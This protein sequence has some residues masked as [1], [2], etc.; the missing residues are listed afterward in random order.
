[1]TRWGKSH[2]WAWRLLACWVALSGLAASAQEPGR[3]LH[4][5]APTRPAARVTPHD[6]Q[7]LAAAF[8]VHSTISTGDL[9]LDELAAQAERAGLDAV[10]LTE[11]FVLRYEYGLP[12]LRRVFKGTVS[13][14]SVLEYGLEQ[15]LADVAAAQARHPRV[16]LVPGV[17][18][19][20]HYFWTGSLLDG[21]LTMHNAQKNVLVLGLAQAAEYRALP[22]NGNPGSYR[23]GWEAAANLAPALLLV[24]A[25]WLWV[26]RTDRV[27]PVGRVVS[28]QGSRHRGAALLLT[29][30]GGFL[31]WNGWPPGAPPFSVYD[32]RLGYRPYQALIDAV[33]A[34]GG[35]TV[36]SMPEARDFHVVSYGPLGQV[37]IKTD[38]YPEALSDTTGYTAFGGV[39]QDTRT[40]TDPGGLWDQ[41]LGQYVSGQRAE[42][43][44]AVGELAFH[45]LNRDTQ[46]LDQVLTVFLVR[47]RSAAGLLEALR[48]GR[49]YAVGQYRRGLGLRLTRFRAECD[50]G[51]RWAESGEWLDPCAARDLS[52]HVAVS[53]TDGGAHPIR[54]TLVRSGQVLAQVEGLTPFDQ[55]FTDGE[56]PPGP[57]RFYRVSV[58]TEGAELLSNPVFVGSS[59]DRLQRLS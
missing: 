3:G 49:L 50:G 11:N 57:G 17:E 44:F 22:A 37:T 27:G 10:V 8:H 16:L 29:A 45:G 55:T 32:D 9:T 13:L 5:S 46:E 1:M 33:T 53:A 59:Q 43:P 54:V 41:V 35:V 20:P 18:V 56:P 12:P 28:R 19:V 7:P 23:Y 47:D 42:P 15:F 4:P 38:P 31:L 6:F 39:Y 21:T 48:A 26:R 40:I 14:P 25:T 58:E 36:W 24:P 2:P 30:L 34:R 51:T 52:V